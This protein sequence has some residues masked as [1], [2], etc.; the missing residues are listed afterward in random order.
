MQANNL[1]RENQPAVTSNDMPIHI[2]C[3]ADNNY[4][5]PLAV[6][7]CSMLS[8][9]QSNRKII[10]FIIDGG[11]KNHNKRKILNSLKSDRCK[12]NFVKIPSYLLKE[13]DRVHNPSEIKQIKADYVSIASFYRLLIPDLLPKEIDKVIYLDCD[14]IVRGN[15]ENLWKIDIGNNYL[16]AAQDTSILSLSNPKSK[17]NCQKL[18]LNP[19]AKYFNAGVL[20]INLN[21]WREDKLT[22]RAIDYLQQNLK[23]IGWY[24]QGVLNGLFADR[25]QELDPRWNMS[26]PSTYGY[27]SWEQSPFSEEVYNN[28][29]RDPYIIHFLSKPKPW[30]SRHALGKEKFFEYVDKTKW[31]GWR[32][33]IWRRLWFRSIYE[34]QLI[35]RKINR[36]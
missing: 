24:D 17:L 19:K 28:L 32:L 15:I 33:T 16:L 18:G 30:T 26:P 5:M 12:V 23:Y 13:I 1:E 11:I 29:I 31:S 9:H 4:A 22:Q 36:L 6:M 27:T 21:K 20:V 14:I 25:W 34:F 8:N 2:V 35:M 7:A 3:A 10:L